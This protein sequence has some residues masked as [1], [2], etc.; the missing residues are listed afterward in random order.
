MHNLKLKK[1]KI[2]ES[3]GK[4]IPSPYH[5]APSFYVNA[6]QM[7][8]IESWE[9]GKKYKLVIEVEQKSKN[10]RE[11]SIDASFDILAYK[12]LKEKTIDEMSDKEFEEE[13]GKALANR[14]QL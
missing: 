4:D 13:K 8:E 10:E 1:I 14:Y 9:V 6:E 5:S 7:P 2:S 11:D 12:H 3:H